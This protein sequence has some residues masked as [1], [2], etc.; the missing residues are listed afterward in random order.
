MHLSQARLDPTKAT[1]IKQFAN[2]V[3]KLGNGTLAKPNDGLVEINIPPEF[4]IMHFKDVIQAIVNSKYPDLT[5][6]CF[7]DKYL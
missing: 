5:K 1:K 4:L 7:N 3:A 2:W 6:N